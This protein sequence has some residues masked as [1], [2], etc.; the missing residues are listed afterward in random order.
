MAN[1]IIRV[2]GTEPIIHATTKVTL[3]A[4]KVDGQPE[5]WMV[6][7]IVAELP[8]K[9]VRT[10]EFTADEMDNLLTGYQAIK[11]VIR[12]SGEIGDCGTISTPTG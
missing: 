8:V 12:T 11:S 10:L 7:F 9:A 5:R 1:F 2:P 3:K 6:S 4:E